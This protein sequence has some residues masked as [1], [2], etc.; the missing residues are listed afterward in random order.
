[1]WRGRMIRAESSTAG[2]AYRIIH[3]FPKPGF[4]ESYARNA[5][6]DNLENGQTIH[7]AECVRVRPGLPPDRGCVRRTSRSAL[8]CA[9]AMKCRCG[10][11]SAHSRVPFPQ[12]LGGGIRCAHDGPGWYELTPLAP[13]GTANGKC[14]NSRCCGATH[15]G[16]AR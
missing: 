15:E 7:L 9:E 13:T 5:S 10:W 8:E 4:E 3:A 6:S 14:P 16:F 2:I 11:C 12:L 1:A